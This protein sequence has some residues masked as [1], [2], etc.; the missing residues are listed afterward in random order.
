MNGVSANDF[1]VIYSDF[2]RSATYQQVTKTT[3]FNGNETSVYD[4]ATADIV[5]FLEENRYLFDVQGLT[6]VGDAYLMC[7]AAGLALTYNGLKVTG[8]NNGDM[9]GF[10][11]NDGISDGY[12]SYKRTDGLAFIYSMNC[13]LPLPSGRKYCIGATKGGAPLYTTITNDLTETFTEFGG[14]HTATAITTATI[15]PQRY[16]KVSIDGENYVIETVLRRHVTTV[17][18]CY[19]AVLFK[20]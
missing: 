8:G 3:D 17:D 20:V 19:F 6:E 2:K 14:A 11:A 18:M 7:P 15:I 1:L 10:Y 5:F 16:D 4:N 9:T 12:M 13:L